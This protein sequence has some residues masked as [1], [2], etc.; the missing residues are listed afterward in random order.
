MEIDNILMG[1]SV[2]PSLQQGKRGKTPIDM[3]MILTRGVEQ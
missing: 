3:G 1:T 2:S